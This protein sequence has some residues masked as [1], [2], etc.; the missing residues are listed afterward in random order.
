MGAHL[1]PPK[2]HRTVVSIIVTLAIALLVTVNSLFLTVSP[3]SAK[4]NDI[5]NGIDVGSPTDDVHYW[6]NCQVQ[7]F[8]GGPDGWVIVGNGYNT[9]PNDYP[10]IYTFQTAVVKNGMLFGWFDQGGA[11][12]SLG[13][14]TSDEQD[15]GIGVS[16][17]VIQHFQGG[18]LLWVPGMDHAQLIDYNYWGAMQWALH[19][20]PSGTCTSPDGITDYVGECLWFVTDAY[21][22][23]MSHWLVGG[24]Y[25][26]NASAYQWWYDPQGPGAGNT[27]APFGSLVVWNQGPYS[28]DGHIALG[29]GGGYMLSTEDTN[30][31]VTTWTIH[32]ERIADHNSALYLGWEMPQW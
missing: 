24:P 7:D 8:N 27:N 19:C 3:A 25:G 12:G 14:P 23:G 31:G 29:L 2:R 9:P 5:V 1:V 6:G 30:N 28:P 15:A 4:A 13:C 22:N 11:T 18:D 26:P 17:A 16:G 21:H 10:V 20:I 32:V